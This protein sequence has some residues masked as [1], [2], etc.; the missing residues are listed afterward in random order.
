MSRL[1]SIARWLGRVPPALAVAVGV[2]LLHL[3]IVPGW[4]EPR[5]F[6]KYPSAARALADGT[7][8]PARTLDFS[9]LYLGLHRAV[10]ALGLDPVAVVAALQALA[11]AAAAGLLFVLLRRW[12]GPSLALAGVAVFALDRH[13]LIYR[14]VLEPEILLLAWVVALLVF[15]ERPGRTAAIAAGLSGALAIATRPS[16][17]PLVALA[18]VACAFAGAG[19]EAPRR[20]A[21]AARAALFAAPV[22][23]ALV[24][25]AVDAARVTGSPWTPRMNPGRSSTRATTRF[26]TAPARSIR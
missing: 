2:L 21:R 12:V 22:V 14:S 18:A 13:V 26:R 4:M 20:A 5:F 11:V 9:P 6:L 19:V 15:A 25:L 7:M 17:L 3:L 16:A 1:E 8:A 10:V 24:A 23:V